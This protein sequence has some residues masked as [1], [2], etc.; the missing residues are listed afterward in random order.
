MLLGIYIQ[1]WVHLIGHQNSCPSD[2][3]I[4]KRECRHVGRKQKTQGEQFYHASKSSMVRDL[5]LM[6]NGS[7]RGIAQS[8]L[9]V[10]QFGGVKE[11][12]T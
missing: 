6:Q 1:H 4:P 10:G 7:P 11:Q 2:L 5:C 3:K 8:G 12:I 9:G